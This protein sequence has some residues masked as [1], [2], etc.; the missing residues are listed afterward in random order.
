MWEE[1]TVGRALGASG[2]LLRAISIAAG[3]EVSAAIGSAKRDDRLGRPGRPASSVS[4]LLSVVSRAQAR[5]STVAQR[6]LRR[7]TIAVLLG[8]A[9][10][11]FF[12]VTA[13]QLTGYEP[14]TAAVSEGLV[15]TGQLRVMAGTPS[16][17]EGMV[18][19]GGYRYGRT[20]LTQPL[21]EAPAYWLGMKLDELSSDG[22]NYR[23]RTTLLQLFDPA[24]AAL[25]VVAIF[26]LLVLRG[27]SRRRALIVAALCAVATLIWPYSKIGMDT[28]LMATL[29]L[30]MLAAAWASKRPTAGRLALLGV[31]MALTMNSKAYGAL[32]MLGALPLCASA[33]LRLVRERRIML[34]V[35]FV[36]PVLC[37][38]AAIAWY[39]WY[40][41]GSV[42]NFDNTYIAGRVLALPFSV[43]GLL[44]S[45]GKGLLFYSPLVVLGLLG[46][47]ELSR[48]DRPLARTIVLT[49]AVNILVIAISISW[50]DETWGPRYLVPSA[51]LLVLPI[52]WWVTNRRRRRWLI[53]VAAAGV[54]VQFA[55][56]FVSYGDIVGASRALA[57]EPVYLYNDWSARVAYGDDGPRWIPQAS[58]L[59]VQAEVV[60]AYVKEKLTG[61]GFTVTY[62]PY[63]GNQGRI[64]LRHPERA[65][66]P[67]PDFWWAAAGETTKQQLLA[68][69]LA[70]MCLGSGAMLI[71]RSRRTAHDTRWLAA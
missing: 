59:L 69:L 17:G 28:T 63:R 20:G 16:S 36:I 15:R 37:G 64:D 12:G 33:L 47:R 46:L 67:L 68:A 2:L 9:A 19:R 24:M 21:L 58:P 39:N 18:G 48:D 45:P 60:A 4:T 38:L 50:T 31:A 66:A 70:I 43:A 30:T 23:W 41:T 11:G 61:S 8:L 25:T 57:G 14:E 49:A 52:A 22:R 7:S 1:R 29:A 51:W 26:A 44:V 42:T 71:Q 40:R 62:K 3:G 34:L 27:V 6:G 54:C 56:V 5:G 10:F 65:F 13:G 55:G 53:A 35:A 32:L